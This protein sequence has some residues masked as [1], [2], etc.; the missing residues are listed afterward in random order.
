M[1]SNW[2]W[3]AVLAL[4]L[5]LL[6]IT[7][8][9]ELVRELVFLPVSYLVWLAG[10]VYRSFDQQALWTAMLIVVL[11]LALISLR[12]K[13]EL[14]HQMSSPA[15]EP[16]HRVRLWAKRLKEAQR[17]TYMRWRLAQHIKAL[18]LDAVAYR[19]G[20]SS[21]QVEKEIHA[22]TGDL[23]AELVD[24]LQAARGF[25]TGSSMSRRSTS[26][27]PQPLN[28]PPEAILDFLEGYLDLE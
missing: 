13:P 22:H 10:L 11:I 5:G 23:P 26:S 7:F 4:V 12:L 28:L 19:S 6:A 2:V 25:E 27:I 21:E 18:A 16:P 1:K 15:A 8:W 24:Y 3:A 20:L 14:M 9:G 17:G